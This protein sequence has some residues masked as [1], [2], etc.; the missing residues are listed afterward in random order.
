[1]PVTPMAQRI[2]KWPIERLIP[3]ARNP[4][5]HSDAQVAQIAASIAAFG[6][7][8]PILV[9]TKAGIL[10]G[11]GRF[12]AARKL[13]LRE[14]PVIVLDHLT[15]AQK[16]AYIIADNQLALNAGWDE[17]LLRAELAASQGEDFNVRLIGFE[18]EELARLL[19]AQDAAA[20]LT[21]EDSVP[22]LPETP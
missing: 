16:R 5:T 15:D 8:N 6:F 4:R 13:Q 19:A 17:T 9:D 20:G 7:N 10:A 2:E 11:N 14:V 12:L 21:D 1:M 3:W 22:E 18:D